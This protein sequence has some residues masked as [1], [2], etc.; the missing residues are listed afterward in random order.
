MNSKYIIIVDG[1]EYNVRDFHENPLFKWEYVVQFP[2][3]K[4]DWFCFYSMEWF[5]WEYVLQFPN[6]N[7]G[8]EWFHTLDCFKWEYILQFPDKDWSW[9]KFHTLDCFKW[10]YVLQFPDKEWNWWNFHIMEWFKWEHFVYIFKINK[11]Y[12]I[13]MMEIIERLK[14]KQPLLISNIL[15]MDYED[16]IKEDMI[17]YYINK[18]VNIKNEYD[19]NIY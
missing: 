11:M 19:I 6:K 2:E 15:K 9:W 3:K 13:Y 16:F 14:N 5:K 1:N 10:K 7:W 4:W 8:W 12:K 18:D 17:Y